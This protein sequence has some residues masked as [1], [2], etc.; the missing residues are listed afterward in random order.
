VA[1]GKGQRKANY[2]LIPEGTA[3]YKLLIEARRKWHRT[4]D[5]ARIALAWRTRLKSDKDGHLVLGK[6]IKVSDLQKEFAEYDFIILLNKEVWDAVDFAREKQL[7][8]LDHELCH[9][10]P[11]LDKFGGDVKDERGRRVWRMRKHDIEEFRS[12]VEHHGTYKRD[13]EA[14]A[15]ALLKKAGAPLLAGVE[16]VAPPQ[17]EAAN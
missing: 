7:A 1:K 9:A 6:C 8:L 11:V 10:A 14:F 16:D 2:T 13:L 15:K 3:P 4:L 5:E 12:V 17:P